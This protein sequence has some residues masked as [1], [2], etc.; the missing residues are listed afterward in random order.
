M[1]KGDIIQLT[2]FVT[3]QINLQGRSLAEIERLIGYHTGRLA[4]GATFLAAVELPQPKGF[5]LA[6]YSQV[7]EQ[8][9]HKQYKNINNPA[10]PI[11]AQKKAMAASQ[12]SLHGSNRL[13]KVLPGIRHN[14]SMQPDDQYPPGSGIPQWK[15]ILP[16]RFQVEAVVIDYASGRFIPTQGF[17]E[18]KYR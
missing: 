11:L 7:A 15:L 5:E 1:K 18:V 10:D 17:Q 9:T 13:V 14:A 16:I 12:W 6:G 3:R 4:Q 2:G 8:H